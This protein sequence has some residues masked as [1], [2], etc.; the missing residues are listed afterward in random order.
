MGLWYAFLVYI[1][2]MG[3]V[4]FVCS[5]CGVSCRCVVFGVG[6]CCRYLMFALL[7]DF[8]YGLLVLVFDIDFQYRFL[9]SAFGV[10]CAMDFSYGF[11]I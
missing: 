7:V 9:V 4:R 5:V 2:D 1:F 3:F 6:F 10:F 11:L 8:W